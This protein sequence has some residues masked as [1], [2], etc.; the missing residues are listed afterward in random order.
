M[1]SPDTAAEAAYDL[2]VEPYEDQAEDELVLVS[3]EVLR[4][5]IDGAANGLANGLGMTGGH[6]RDGRCRKHG[7]RGCRCGD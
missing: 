5:L 3:D 1:R 6:G 4:K 2:G 7:I